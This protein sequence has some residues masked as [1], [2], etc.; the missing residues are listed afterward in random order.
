[1]SSIVEKKLNQTQ[2]VWLAKKI[3]ECVPNADIVRKMKEEHGVEISEHLIKYYM[4][5]SKTWKKNIQTLRDKFNA[6]IEGEPIASPR[7]RMSW[8]KRLAEQA[9]KNGR[10]REAA[11]IIKIAYEQLQPLITG[12]KEIVDNE[13]EIQRKITA[14]LGV[15]SEETAV[16]NTA[17]QASGDTSGSDTV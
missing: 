9:E 10:P 15:V 13:G 5:T 12:S 14:I 1:M 11:E 3:A 8:L 7:Y 6:Q 17:S 4:Y 2:K 16:S